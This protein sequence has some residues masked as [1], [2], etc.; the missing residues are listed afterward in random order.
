MNERSV[1]SFMDTSDSSPL[2]ETKNHEL[3]T[4]MR[5]QLDGM[6]VV[7]QDT[8]DISVGNAAWTIDTVSEYARR[9]C[10][11]YRFRHACE[12]GNP[13]SVLDE[14]ESNEDVLRGY[15][16]GLFYSSD[17]TVLPPDVDIVRL[18]YQQEDEQG[19]LHTM[20]E[21][22]LDAPDAPYYAHY[23]VEFL[24]ML[25]E[26]ETGAELLNT[27][28]REKRFDERIYH[29]IL[30]RITL[31]DLMRS[32]I[33]F[34]RDKSAQE[35]A[36]LAREWCAG[37]YRAMY[38]DLSDDLIDGSAFYSSQGMAAGW[39]SSELL[40]RF[41]STM[42]AIDT[43]GV[44]TAQE[45]FETCGLTMF[46]SYS[47][48]QL[49][50]TYEVFCDND[51][52]EIE[53]LQG[54]DTRVVF[55]NSGGDHN[56]ALGCV[57]DTYDIQGNV[58]FFEVEKFE[59][60]YEGFIKLRKRGIRPSSLVL[61]QHANA[62]ELNIRA[63]SEPDGSMQGRSYS[64]Y[65]A[66]TEWIGKNKDT[67]QEER[68]MTAYSVQKDANGFSRLMSDR[69]MQPSVDSGRKQVI[70]HG[71]LLAKIVQRKTVDSKCDATSFLD[72]FAQ[73]VPNEECETD[74]Y[75]FDKAIAMN[76]RDDVLIATIPGDPD[77]ESLWPSDSHVDCDAVKVSVRGGEMSKSTVSEIPLRQV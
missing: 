73:L 57:P 51:T 6:R 25:R 16:L 60:I 19:D 64:M 9:A 59:D 61:A 55:I 41:T 52:E 37:Y 7:N 67:L 74:I 17:D 23:I 54:V 48:E 70:L 1:P 18:A 28:N 72:D 8:S 29:V 69:Y 47:L 12:E 65:S 15:L 40:K 26:C 44:D 27:L 62:G 35:F 58:L 32:E 39:P 49:A 22:V 21:L 68:N 77:E 11:L 38:P 56:G 34:G 45:L 63:K 3:Y 5:S 20:C 4:T 14:C 66:S 31:F 33:G 53:R 30:S 71:C 75:G 24:K 76:R 43:I 42:D 10:E 36:Q 13:D 46:G 2:F 50:R